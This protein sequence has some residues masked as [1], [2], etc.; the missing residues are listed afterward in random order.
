MNLRSLFDF[1]S[2]LASVEQQVDPVLRGKTLYFGDMESALEA[3]PM[4]IPFSTIPIPQL[5]RD[6]EHNEPWLERLRQFKRLAET[7]HQR[8]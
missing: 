5:E 6:A 8:P 4:R 1:N 2:Y 7:V 3:A